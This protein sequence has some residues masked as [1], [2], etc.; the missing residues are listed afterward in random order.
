MS[1]KPKPQTCRRPVLCIAHSDN[2]TLGRFPSVLSTLQC[3]IE[4]V[5]FLS[6]G[7]PDHKA[8]RYD[9]VIIF[10]G[11]AS[12]AEGLGAEFVP[13]IE[14]IECAVRATT[15]VLGICLGGQIL[16]EIFCSPLRATV[17]SVPEVGFTEIIPSS[18]DL[19]SFWSHKSFFQ[20]H[21]DSMPC[22]TDAINLGR[23]ERFEC[24]A[25]SIDNA[26]ALQFHPDATIDTIRSWISLGEQTIRDH[27]GR[28]PE[29]HI[30]EA[31]SHEDGVH[32]WT[33]EL[34]RSLIERKDML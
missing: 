6:G 17:S 26:V 28:T 14:F 9:A 34:M 5:N 25:Y 2:N 13:E 3:S 12:T 31:Q 4:R 21:W 8:Q 24:Q 33:T 7:T 1:A 16:S 15:P 22:P 30:A 18:P 10:G 23:T 19:N 11:L 27:S 20:W 29:E 32:Q